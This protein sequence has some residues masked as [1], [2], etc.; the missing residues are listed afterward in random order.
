MSTFSLPENLKIIEG[1]SPRIGT[2][3]SFVGDYISVKNY[4]RVYIVWHYQS[5]AAVAETLGVMESPLVSGVGAAAST[6]L[7][8]WWSCLD[9]ATS[10][11][12]VERTAAAT[13]QMPAATVNNIVVCEVDPA[14][15]T[16]GY[17]CIA[18]YTTSGIAV[19]ET[20]SM[21]YYCVPRFAS[22]VLTQTTS[23]TD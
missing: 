21:M 14:L 19:T 22:R 20:I 9:C 15:L 1:L 8:R 13:Y 17:D 3:V 10:D 23:L 5:V 4:H 11:L 12:M 6:A 2:T 16:A 18:G 7:F